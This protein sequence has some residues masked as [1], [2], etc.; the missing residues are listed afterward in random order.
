MSLRQWIALILV[1]PVVVIFWV[2]TVFEILFYPYI[3]V[4]VGVIANGRWIG[5]KEY[6]DKVV[7]RPF[8]G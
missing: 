6:L 4:V 5:F 8:G 7:G 2:F 1:I 3:A